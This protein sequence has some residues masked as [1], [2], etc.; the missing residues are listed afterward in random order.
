VDNADDNELAKKYGVRAATINVW[1]K[2]ADAQ[3]AICHERCDQFMV[4]MGLKVCVSRFVFVV[5]V[6]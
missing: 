5:S 1:K 2:D 6:E 3:W 4:V